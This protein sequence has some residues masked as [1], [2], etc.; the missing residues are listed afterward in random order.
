MSSVTAAATAGAGAGAG[1]CA[2][3]ARGVRP[4][5]DAR[6]PG[7]DEE[8]L[9][10]NLFGCCCTGAGRLALDGDEVGVTERKGEGEPGVSGR[11]K[12]ELR[13]EGTAREGVVFVR[14]SGRAWNLLAE[15]LVESVC[16]D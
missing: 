5:D 14:W 10:E 16:L 7:V 1:G 9:T 3:A 8:V 4:S 15:S 2:C 13:W 11:R 6:A 12:G